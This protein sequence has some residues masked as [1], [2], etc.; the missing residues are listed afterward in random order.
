MADL[1]PAAA[2]VL[3]GT[4]ALTRIAFAGAT[5]TAGE[6]VYFDSGTERLRLAKS[7][8]NEAE[9]QAVG[10]AIYSVLEDQPLEYQYDGV[11]KL[12]VGVKSLAYFLSGTAGNFSP[13]SDESTPAYGEYGTMMGVADANSN[14][15]LCI[16]W[17]PDALA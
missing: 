8:G 11:I 17:A 7:S 2:D 16:T 4:G 10:V 6:I 12:G 15:I 5:I 13:H 1:A 9:S 14:M 3:P